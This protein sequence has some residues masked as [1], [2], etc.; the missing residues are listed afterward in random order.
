M[1]GNK[2]EWSEIYAFLKLLAD[3]KLFSADENLELIPNLFYPILKVLRTETNGHRNYI[4]NSTIKVI[5]PQKDLILLEIPI[6]KFATAATLLLDKIKS[7]AT[8]TFAVAEIEEFLEFIHV[9]SLKAPSADKRDISIVVHDLRTNM[10]PTLGFSIKSNLGGPST[11]LNAGKTTNFVY[12]IIGNPFS[13]NE[14]REIN[15]ISSR[16]KV[17]DR[18]AAIRAKGRT[19]EYV[20]MTCRNFNINLQMID[21]RM[22]EIIAEM[23][24]LFF[25]GKGN[26]TKDLVNLLERLNPLGLDLGLHHPLYEYKVKALLTDIAL[27]MTP[28]TLWNGRYDATGG[29]IIV[30]AGGDIV[31]Y[32][33][34][35]RNE[36][37]NYLLN[38]TKLDTPGTDRH[39]FGSIYTFNGVQRINLN[40]QIRFR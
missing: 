8:T 33:I 12:R 40:L 22:P 21:I 30:K 37:Q 36:F 35:N 23:L 29:Y 2:G 19:L 28:S 17:R 1:T 9:R 3:G 10:T 16:S 7:S 15:A 38:R 27:G 13:Q 14:I 32:H 5:D 20:E 18:L 34:Y 31:C 26:G 6:A 25:D 39:G 4:R 24:L 11:L